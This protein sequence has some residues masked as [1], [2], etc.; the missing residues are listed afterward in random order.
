MVRLRED[1]VDCERR[2]NA[3]KEE[4]NGEGEMRM[5]DGW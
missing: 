1:V 3:M 4:A 5:S 2:V